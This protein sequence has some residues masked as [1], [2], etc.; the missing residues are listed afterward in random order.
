MLRFKTLCL[1][2]IAFS[3]TLPIP[4]FAAGQEKV[5][6]NFARGKLKG[7]W[8]EGGVILDAAGNLYGTANQGGNME[9][10]SGYGCGTVFELSPGAG[11][12]WT[13]TV[14]H[15]FTGPDGAF[16]DSRLTFDAAG[17]LYGTS[18]TGGNYDEHCGGGWGCGTVFELSP[19][20]D[21][22]W[23]EKA[24]YTF[25]PS[26]GH[27]LDGFSPEGGVVLDAEGNLYGTVEEGAGHFRG[28]V[29]ELS[30][31]PNGTW[32][33]TL[34]YSFGDGAYPASGVIFDNAGNLYGE[35]TYGGGSGCGPDSG[36][37]GAIFE[38]SPSPRGGKW[39]ET[40]LYNF[41]DANG[42]NGAFPGGGLIFDASGNLYGTTY[43]GGAHNDGTVFQLSPGANGTW[44]ETVLRRF[45]DDRSPNGVI[46]DAAGNLFGTSG[47]G[48]PGCD[49][50]YDWGCGTIF[51]LA[52]GPGGTWAYAELFVFRERDGYAPSGV[53]MDAAGN[54]YGTTV[55]GGA[56]LSACLGGGIKGCGTVFEFTP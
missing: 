30:P 8:P 43:G 44:T 23:T 40:I 49:F 45:Y 1:A 38:L 39:Q 37:C 28:A 22:K 36:G 50:E 25:C 31:G 4:T 33:E 16:P 56:Y 13:E 6:Y 46:L 15:K 55:F 41:N 18:W 47:V 2:A 17:N 7:I 10:C 48:G 53:V 52:P 24:L 21:G 19:G 20:P 11:G 5:L 26:G 14:L 54:L 34:L 51:K 42:A 35:A 9:T 12:T 29:F 32:A 3:S 27:C